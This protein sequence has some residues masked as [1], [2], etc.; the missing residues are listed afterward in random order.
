M[1]SKAHD[2]YLIFNSE[3]PEAEFAQYDWDKTR[4]VIRKGRES[5]FPDWK[6][7]QKSCHYH[8]SKSKMKYS[9]YISQGNTVNYHGIPVMIDE[10]LDVSHD[11]YPTKDE[12]DKYPSLCHVGIVFANMETRIVLATELKPIR[13]S[14]K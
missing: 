12:I 4:E 1:E 14:S 6:S 9:D 5:A 13:S 11:N 8:K 2:V 7:L 10:V 3:R